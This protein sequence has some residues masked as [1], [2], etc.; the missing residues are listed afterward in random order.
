MSFP[1]LIPTIILLEGAPG[2]GKST[3]APFWLARRTG[4][5]VVVA[6]PTRIAAMA[7]SGYVM[8]RTSEVGGKQIY[9]LPPGL[10]PAVYALAGEQRSPSRDQWATPSGA[11][12]VSREVPNR[13]MW[14]M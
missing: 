9:R 13:P 3:V 2:S 5:P 11:G 7:L 14:P 6:V 4:R 1:T 12:P 10:A 8:R